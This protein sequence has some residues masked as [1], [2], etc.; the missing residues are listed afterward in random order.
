MFGADFN[1][2][3]SVRL[4]TVTLL[5]MLL[6]MILHEVAHGMVARRLGDPTAYTMGRLTLNPLPHI[7]PLGLVC[8]VLTSLAGGFIFG[9]AKPVPV[10]PRFFRKPARDMMWVALAGPLA[11]LGL[12]VAFGLGMSLCLALWPQLLYSQ[13]PTQLFLFQMCAQGVLVNFCLMW[14]NLIPLPPLDGSRVV[15]N[16]LPFRLAMSYARLERYGFI[17]LLVLLFSGVL[18]RVLGPLIRISYT[19]VVELAVG[20]L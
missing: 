11:N 1:L 13:T 16:F 12:A 4:L 17:L 10:N 20:L 8:F 9:W 6:G 19:A 7:D 14:F 15:A 18:G 2:A 3:E 5:P